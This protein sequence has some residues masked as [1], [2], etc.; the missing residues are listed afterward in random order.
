MPNN[1]NKKE[2]FTPGPLHDK[3][4]EITRLLQDLPVRTGDIIFRL[5]DFRFFGIPFSKLVAK[6]TKSLYDHATIISVENDDIYVIEVSDMGTTKYLMQDWLDFSAIEQFEIYRV[7]DLT[8][9]Q[10]F[11]LKKVIKDFLNQDADYD[12]SF[13]Q[14][15]NLYYC[16]QSV[17]WLYEKIGINLANPL[18]LDQIIDNSFSYYLIAIL[19]KI[20]FPLTGKGIPCDV[21]LH[22][23]GNEKVGLMSSKLLERIYTNKLSFM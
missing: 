8:Y 21:P 1:K 10:L 3:R 2:L 9:E 12:Y 22:I 4:R 6:A 23:V 16:T 20:I 17:Y 13:G 11:D 15:Q 18:Y 14:K 5:D 19:S 7:K